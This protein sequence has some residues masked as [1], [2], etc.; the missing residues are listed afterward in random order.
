MLSRLYKYGWLTYIGGGMKK[1]G[2]HNVLEA[3]VYNKMVLFGP[4]YQKYT[5]ATGLVN[6]G[7]GI[8]FTDEQ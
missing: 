5:E 4:F 7:G 2:V 1:N 3:A 8:S 6:T